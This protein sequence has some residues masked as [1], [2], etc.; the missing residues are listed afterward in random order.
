MQLLLGPQSAQHSRQQAQ[1]QADVVDACL[2]LLEDAEPRV[3]LAVGEC[4]GLLAEQRGVEVWEAS[5][6]AVLGSINRCWVSIIQCLEYLMKAHACV[7][8]RSGI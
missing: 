4:L 5:R 1:V 6:A 7:Y 8:I 3:R 2:T